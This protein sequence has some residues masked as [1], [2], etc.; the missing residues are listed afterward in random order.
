M[1]AFDGFDRIPDMDLSALAAP[2]LPPEAAAALR[3]RCHAALM[4]RQKRARAGA[5]GVFYGRFIEPVLITVLGAGV[6]FA[7]LVRAVAVLA[8]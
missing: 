3:A 2:D 1:T 8:G 5:C 6:L 4:R 7:T